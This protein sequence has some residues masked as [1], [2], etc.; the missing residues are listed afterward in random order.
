MGGPTALKCCDIHIQHEWTIVPNLERIWMLFGSLRAWVA[1]PLSKCLLARRFCGA[2]RVDGESTV[3][4]PICL[5]Y[6]AGELF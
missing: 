6:L 3:L 1:E 4:N 5:N 2:T